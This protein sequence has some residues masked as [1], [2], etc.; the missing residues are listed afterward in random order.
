MTEML[1]EP[2]YEIYEGED[3]SSLIGDEWECDCEDECGECP[4]RE[5]V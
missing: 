1:F 5:A 3:L 4:C 2:Q